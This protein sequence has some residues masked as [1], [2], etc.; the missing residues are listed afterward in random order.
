MKK[1]PIIIAFIFSVLLCTGQNI[2]KAEYFIDTDPGFGLAIQI[3]VSVPANKVS[4]SFQVNT[5]GLSQGFHMMVLRARD[6]DGR[7]STTRQQVFY[8]YETENVTESNITRAEY[9]IDTD[10]GF[11]LATAIP[12]TTP[13]KKV[14]LSFNVNANSLSE[15]FHM[16]VLRAR[17]QLG[18]WS[19]TRQQVFFVYETAN[20]TESKINKAE[21]FID[22][23]P[24]FGLATQVPVSVPAKKVSLA[25]NVNTTSLSTGFHMMVLRSRDELGRWSN[26]RQ[27]VFYLYKTIPSTVSNVTGIE[28]FIDTDPGFGKG[29]FV[30]AAAPGSKV[31]MDFVASLGGLTA[32]DHLLYIR[33]KDALNR[34]SHPYIHAF[35]LTITGVGKEE[36][37]PWFRMYPNPNEGNFIIDF[38]D[39]QSRAIKITINDLNGRTVYSNEL[40]GENIPLSVDLPTG[41][42][43]LKVESGKQLFMQKLIIRR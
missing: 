4:L 36:V 29:T 14:A 18:R 3:P 15:G 27:Q 6:D 34:W 23:D 16:I 33:S 1:L 13:A 39:L 38:T 37:L 10:P 24:G 20:V 40:E 19:T 2:N 32:G 5:T 11:G 21:Y 8:V 31:S 35:S 43:M 42:Y 30:A 22:N 17:D 41:V 9:F 7:W 12:V 26:T 28:Y 25:F